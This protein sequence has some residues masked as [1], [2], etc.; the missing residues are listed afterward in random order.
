MPVQK[1]HIATV[2]EGFDIWEHRFGGF[3]WSWET[4]LQGQVLGKLVGPGLEPG[5]PSTDMQA[6]GSS[7]LHI[8]ILRLGSCQ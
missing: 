7:S 8:S 3:T 2:S 1:E 6:D 5:T 4:G